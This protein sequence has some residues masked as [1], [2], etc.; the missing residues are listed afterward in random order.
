MSAAIAV[1]RIEKSGPQR[2]ERPRYPYS[3]GELQ[4]AM[5]EW[6]CN[7]GPGALATMLGLKPND[8]RKHIPFFDERRY[9]NPTM[10]K[11]AL[12]SLGVKFSATGVR[13][14]RTEL[15]RYG[16]VRIQWEGPWC[17]PGVPP[18]AAYRQTHWIGAM[19]W[20]GRQFVFDI[21]SGW[22][23]VT[24]WERTTVPSLVALYKK[25]S[26]GWHPTHRWELCL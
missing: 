12:A 11:A 23:H 26:G 1:S 17:K 13:L 6:G 4:E 10:M 21:N 3:S 2:L 5:L 8:V 25:A 24:E 9:T 20:N 15:A 14:P 7:C 22:E 18:A 19:V 16:L